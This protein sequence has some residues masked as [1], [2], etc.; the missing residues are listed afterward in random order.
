MT[1]RI[2]TSLILAIKKRLSKKQFL[3]VSC[4]LVGL[5]S[6]ISAIILKTV[7]F[8]LHMLVALTNTV[9]RQNYLFILF[10]L[11][12]ILL[13]IFTVKFFLKNKFTKGSGQILFSIA[14]KSSI[15]EKSTTYTHLLTSA[16][17]VG[18]GGSAGLEAPIVVTG[19]A[20]GSNYGRVNRMD[21]R[22]RTLMLACGSAAGIAAVFNAPIAGIMFAVEII[23][24]EATLSAFVPLIISAVIGALCSKVV[25]NEGIL[26]VFTL[27][28]PF[29]YVNIP[30]YILLG[31]LAGMISV[32]FASVTLKIEQLSKLFTNRFVKGLIGGLVLGLL[33]FLFPPLFGEGYSSI[34]PLANLQPNSLLND[35]LFYSFNNNEWFVLLFISAICL[36]K[37]IATSITLNFGGNGG[38]FAPS[39]FV[40]AYLGFAFSRFIN[41]LNFSKLPESNFTLVGMAGILSGVMYAPLTGIFLIAEVT[42]GYELM[43]PLMIVSSISYGI[44]RVFEP[45]SMDTRELA[46][47]GD[48]L[49]ANKDKNILTLLDIHEIIENDFSKILYNKKIIDLT[50]LI[51]HSKRNLFPVVDEGDKLLGIVYMENIR[52]ILFELNSFRDLAVIELMKSPPATL[53]INEDMGSVMKK[54]DESKAW[55]LPVLKDDKYIGFI[56]KSSVFSSYRE[57]IIKSHS[58]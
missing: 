44:V 31:L 7:V 39:L 36:I 20:I 22:E 47:K 8:Q 50:E 3:F 58:D 43:I 32:Y 19:A 34:L 17:T 35:S 13:T 48:I 12:G 5:I 11:A 41:L 30:Y 51:S 15:I 16:L 21:Y 1:M 53:Q 45:Y 46:K 42:G 49:T 52:E 54:F 25:L 4:I 24:T 40:G 9:Y 28:Q 14:K 18:F 56:S 23:L 38:N 10:P 29:N 27:K 55:N 2:Y 26:L 33:V 37:V 6:G 57:Q